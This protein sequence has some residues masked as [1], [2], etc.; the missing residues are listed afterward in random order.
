MTTFTVKHTPAAYLVQDAAGAT[1]ATFAFDGD[2]FHGSRRPAYRAALAKAAQLEAAL[3]LPVEAISAPVEVPTYQV[4]ATRTYEV[5][6]AGHRYHLNDVYP[7]CINYLGGDGPRISQAAY[8]ELRALWQTLFGAAPVVAPTAD[9]AALAAHLVGELNELEAL[10]QLP[11]HED[12]Y[13]AKSDQVRALGF[14]IGPAADGAGLSV[15]HRDAPRVAAEANAAIADAVAATRGGYGPSSAELAALHQELAREQAS[16]PMQMPEGDWLDTNG[17]RVP[18]PTTPPQAAPAPVAS[19]V[20]APLTPPAALIEAHLF[21]LEEDARRGHQLC[22]DGGDA[23]GAKIARRSERAYRDAAALLLAGEWHL[24]NRGDVLVRSGSGR[25]IWHR[26]GRVPVAGGE[27]RPIVCTCEWSEKG[28]GLG[29]CRHAA[30]FESVEQAQDE[31][32]TELDAR[33]TFGAAA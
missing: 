20:P 6:V 33:A 12:R 10:G 21:R 28:D 9:D 32:I 23:E 24:T 1:V 7:E 8:A 16:E 14:G 3:V 22:K 4:S 29:P 27:W 30:L 15:W 2:D 17:M 11:A 26:V 13:V 31:Y 25:A 18:A 19:R 5:F